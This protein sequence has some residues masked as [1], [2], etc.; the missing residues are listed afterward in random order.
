MSILGAIDAEFQK[1][2]L[3]FIKKEEQNTNP[4]PLKESLIAE[5]L[6]QMVNGVREITGMATNSGT[7]DV[8]VRF[9]FSL[10]YAKQE[11]NELKKK[12]ETE[13]GAGLCLTHDSENK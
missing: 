11:V 4:K 6:R 10:P 9:S 8:F 13:K 2:L 7:G 12:V 5:L 3:D 1:E